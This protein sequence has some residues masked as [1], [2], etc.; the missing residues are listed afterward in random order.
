MPIAVQTVIVTVA[1]FNVITAPT[2]L[3]S[4]VQ[5][6]THR[7]GCKRTVIVTVHTTVT[8]IKTVIHT[9][10]TVTVRVLRL[11]VPNCMNLV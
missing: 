9:I 3:L 8:Q 10:V 11:F 1:I 5:T 4:T 7:R 2:V 6:V